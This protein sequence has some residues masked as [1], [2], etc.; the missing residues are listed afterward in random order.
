MEEAKAGRRK[1]MEAPAFSGMISPVQLAIGIEPR[2]EKRLFEG[3]SPVAREH[4]EKDMLRLRESLAP[5]RI[6]PKFAIA[7]PDI[8]RQMPMSVDLRTG[9][10]DARPLLPENVR[11]P[12]LSAPAGVADPEKTLSAAMKKIGHR[13]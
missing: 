12:V 5:A 7:S 11:M 3:S 4:Y 13:R 10:I 1:R 9:H 8:T 6:E 2:A